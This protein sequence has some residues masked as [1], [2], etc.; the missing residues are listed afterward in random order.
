MKAIIP[1]L[2]SISLAW[3]AL[4]TSGCGTQVPA[5]VHD[6]YRKTAEDSA[7]L[8]VGRFWVESGAG[9]TAVLAGSVARK[10]PEGDTSKSFLLVTLRDAQGAELLAEKIGFEPQSLPEEWGPHA[11][12][13][14]FRHAFTNFPAKVAQISIKAVD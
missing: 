4:L 2:A 6:G 9:G 12:S 11:K 10:S 7:V 1:L 3:T 5:F 13:A 14:T 8:R